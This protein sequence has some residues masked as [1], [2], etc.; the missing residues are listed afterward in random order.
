MTALLTYLET[1]RQASWAGCL[2]HREAGPATA[3]ST[4]SA[5]ESQDCYSSELLVSRQHLSRISPPVYRFWPL[6]LLIMWHQ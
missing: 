3:A 4:C 5:W 6:L 1:S 2:Y